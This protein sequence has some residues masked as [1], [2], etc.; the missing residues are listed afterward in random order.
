M[1]QDHKPPMQTTDTH[2]TDNNTV[3]TVDH[4]SP[5]PPRKTHPLRSVKQP[6]TWHTPLAEWLRWLNMLW[7][8]R[9]EGCVQEGAREVGQNCQ[10]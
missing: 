2:P 8:G 9:A 4:P 7:L 6:S 5:P 3:S 10:R 1:S